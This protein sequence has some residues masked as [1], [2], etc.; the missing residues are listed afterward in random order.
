MSTMTLDMSASCWAPRGRLSPD[1][2]PLSVPTTPTRVDRALPA[3]DPEGV[4]HCTGLPAFT[5]LSSTFQD[6]QPVG[7]ASWRE[8]GTGSGTGTPGQPGGS[9]PAPH[10]GRG[11]AVRG[12]SGASAPEE[13]V[14]PRSPGGVE[15]GPPV[16]LVQAL[17]PQ[18][19][20]IV[21]SG[22]GPGTS[23][24]CRMSLLLCHQL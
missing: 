3:G 13:R 24:C 18:P 9:S 20:P 22:I 1:V 5:R 16:D 7:R 21:S 15:A 6:Q 12:A 14:P 17:G 10:L 2:G 11:E 4:L 23:H 19:L 8:G